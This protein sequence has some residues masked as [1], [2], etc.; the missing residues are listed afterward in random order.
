MFMML[1]RLRMQ[2][3][4]S[5]LISNAL[6][7]TEQGSIHVAASVSGAQKGSMELRVE[8]K[9]SGMGMTP[10]QQKQLFSPF[11]QADGSITRRFGG[12]GI[13]LALVKGFAELMGGATGCISSGP[14]TGSTFWFTALTQVAEAPREVWYSEEDQDLPCPQ[15]LKL[16]VVDDTKMNLELMKILINRWNC[17]GMYFESGPDAVA[18]IQTAPEAQLPDLTFMD[19]HMPVMDGCQATAALLILKPDMPIIGLTA[20]VTPECHSKA[21]QSGMQ[22]VLPKPYKEKQLI[23]AIRQYMRPRT[24]AESPETAPLSEA[25][26]TRPPSLTGAVMDA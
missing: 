7:F 25:K 13:G 19:F 16:M 8:V 26:R 12:T 17:F 5:N 24:E 21:M 1:D 20:D 6:Q 10:A 23:R 9:D 22:A 18:F 15:G 14:G 4:L 2:Q 3:M 11:T